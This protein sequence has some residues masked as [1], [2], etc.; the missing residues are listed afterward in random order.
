M[1]V[2]NPEVTLE[3]E[4]HEIPE[5]A[6]P[7][8]QACY[9]TQSCV[10][11]DDGRQYW[12]GLGIINAWEAD[13][14]NWGVHWSKGKV[15]QQPGSVYKI[16][17]FPQGVTGWHV[18]P[19]NSITRKRSK[20]EVAVDLGDFHILCKD[21]KTWHFSVEDKENGMNAELVHTGVGYP[22][23]YG[24]E[25]AQ[26]YTPHT[27]SYG[28][29]WSGTVE[30]VLTIEGRKVRVKGAGV[31]ENYYAVDTCPVEVG[32]WHDWI[33]FHFDEMSGSFN[34]MKL[35]K[36]KDMSLYLI[37]EKQYFQTGSFN[38]EHQDWAYH[39]SLGAFI[40]TLYKMTV[41]TEA[42]VL[43][44]AA[45]VVMC[46]VWA[47]SGEVPDSP[48]ASL[49]W[50]NIDGVFTYKDGRKRTLTNGLGGTLIRQWKPYPNV[51]S[52]EI[53]GTMATEEFHPV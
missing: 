16:A 26:V 4:G 18:F 8:A 2:E 30:G 48:T 21:G 19:K 37:D 31:R 35:T 32:G 29:F 28:Y 46:H 38:I 42:G 36:H 12:I 53:G 15:V 41:E 10:W 51:I 3:V 6:L 27:V 20:H 34:E 11:G 45:T 24:K 17:D 43:E 33:W 14:S 25:K 9:D 13:I 52:P 50:D 39:R 49:T 47:A 23:W 44:M 40:P 22:T 5:E 1:I 7:T